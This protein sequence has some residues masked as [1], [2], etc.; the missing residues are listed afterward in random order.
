MASPFLGCNWIVT[1]SPGSKS[2]PATLSLLPAETF[3]G[4]SI[5]R[6]RSLGPLQSRLRRLAGRTPWRIN[7]GHVRE[8]QT[9]IDQTL[10][11]V[12]GEVRAAQEEPGHGGGQDDQREGD[13]EEVEGDEGQNG[14]AH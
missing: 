8:L 11:G 6:G 1:V 4:T 5:A 14:E 10:E 12:P 3:L 9:H 13:R 7:L 2:A